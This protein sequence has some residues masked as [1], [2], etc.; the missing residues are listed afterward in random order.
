MVWCNVIMC[1][2]FTINISQEPFLLNTILEVNYLNKD[3]VEYIWYI[4]LFILLIYQHIYVNIICNHPIMA[5]WQRHPLIFEVHMTI[6]IDQNYPCHI[7]SES[8]EGG[9]RVT[10]RQMYGPTKN[11]ESNI[12]DTNKWRRKKVIDK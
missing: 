4:V 7:I 10:N 3:K 2:W 9:V 1:L 5:F 11:L 8:R 12:L 6:W